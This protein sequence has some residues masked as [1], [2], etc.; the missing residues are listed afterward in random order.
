MLAKFHAQMA[1]NLPKISDVKF[2]VEFLLELRNVGFITPCDEEI[3]NI[4]N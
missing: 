4:D 2:L 1:S 3:T